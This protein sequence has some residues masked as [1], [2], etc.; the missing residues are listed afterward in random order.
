MVFLTHSQMSKMPNIL[1]LM[2]W[3]HQQKWKLSE[4]LI[5]PAIAI[6]VYMFLETVPCP[7]CSDTGVSVLPTLTSYCKQ[8]ALAS[9]HYNGLHKKRELVPLEVFTTMNLIKQ[10]VDMSQ[11]RRVWHRSSTPSHSLH[12]PFSPAPCLLVLQHLVSATSTIINS[13]HRLH[14]Q[15]IPLITSY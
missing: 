8:K 3:Q 12:L 5:L 13:V 1:S 2:K 7:N 15:L 11:G 4:H 6:W 9:L 14:D 10:P